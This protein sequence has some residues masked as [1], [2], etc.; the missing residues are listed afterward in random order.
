VVDGIGGG[1]W[2]AATRASGRMWQQPPEFSNNSNSPWGKIGGE[3]EENVWLGFLV[4]FW[5]L[6]HLTGI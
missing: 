5:D 3:E 4:I 1:G 6:S 2:L